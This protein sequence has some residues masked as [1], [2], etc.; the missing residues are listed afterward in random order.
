MSALP[1][2]TITAAAVCRVCD[3]E[4]GAGHDPGLKPPTGADG[5]PVDLV[6][7]GL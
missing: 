2:E 4:H 3:D 6:G 7:H 1:L 5:V